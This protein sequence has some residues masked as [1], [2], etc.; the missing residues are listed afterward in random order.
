MLVPVRPVPGLD[1]DF[2]FHEN[3]RV[4]RL[5]RDEKSDIY[6]SGIQILNPKRI[7]DLTEEADTFNSVWRQLMEHRELL[8]SS[9][10]PEKWFAV[11]TIEQLAAINKSLF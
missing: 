11:D 4:N 2:I 5:S 3:G 10:Y 6:C 7:N 1:G 9:V 8:I